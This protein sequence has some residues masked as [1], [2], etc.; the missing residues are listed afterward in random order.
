MCCLHVCLY[1]CVSGLVFYIT[2]VIIIAT[3]CTLRAIH[4][5]YSPTY[6]CVCAVRVFCVCVFVCMCVCMCV[7]VCVHVCAC[8]YVCA[9]VCVCVCT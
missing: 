7:H 1:V 3:A 4:H 6:V 9:C 5:V 8:V 2:P